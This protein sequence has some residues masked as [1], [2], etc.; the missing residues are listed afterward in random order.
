MIEPA[1]MLGGLHHRHEPPGRR[2]RT[3]PHAR[4]VDT[5]SELFAAIVATVPRDAMLANGQRI[6]EGVADDAPRGVQIS[7]KTPGDGTDASLRDGAR[8]VSMCFPIRSL[9]TEDERQSATAMSA[10][11]PVQKPPLTLK[12]YGPSLL[13]TS[14][15]SNPEVVIPG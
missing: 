6:V 3:S 13:G 4:E 14:N 12:M 5:R 15:G 1:T 2:H 9:E 8:H 7:A 10:V 11:S